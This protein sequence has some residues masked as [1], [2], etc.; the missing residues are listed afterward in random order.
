MTTTKIHI[1]LFFTEGAKALL[2]FT[3]AFIIFMNSSIFEAFAML[4]SDL[5]KR[6]WCLVLGVV[7]GLYSVPQMQAVGYLFVVKFLK[8]SLMTL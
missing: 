1:Q 7:E 5:Q 8:C 6:M 3:F 2:F 4:T